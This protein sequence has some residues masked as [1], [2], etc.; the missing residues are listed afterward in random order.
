[1]LCA[2][3]CRKGQSSDCHSLGAH[4]LFSQGAALPGELSTSLLFQGAK[5]MVGR[6]GRAL[7]G[8]CQTSAVN[9]LTFKGSPSV[10]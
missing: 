3:L 4:N 1:M 10:P 6:A 2:S 8:L 7:P 9:T 5:S